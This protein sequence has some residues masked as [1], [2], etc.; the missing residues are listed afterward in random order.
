MDLV[1]LLDS[2]RS[3]GANNFLR[4]K[5]LMIEVV[6]AINIDDGKV[7]VAVVTF[8]T[9]SAVEFFLDDFT[10]KKD[11]QKKIKG[12]VYLEGYTNIASGLSLVKD[13]VFQVNKGDR[14]SVRNVLLLIVDGPSNRNS[15]LTIPTAMLLKESGVHVFVLG[16]QSADVDE[17][18]GI[19]S[20]PTEINCIKGQF[21]DLEHIEEYLFKTMCTGVARAEAMSSAVST[22]APTTPDVPS[23]SWN[24]VTTTTDTTPT[25]TSTTS[26]ETTTTSKIISTTKTAEGTAITGSTASDTTK[27]STTSARATTTEATSVHTTRAGNTTP[28]TSIT[29]T[30]TAGL[31]ATD[32]TPLFTTTEGTGSTTPVT[33]AAKDT[34]PTSF[35]TL[36]TGSTTPSTS[37]NSISTTG[38]T[39][40]TTTDTINPAST[41]ASVPAP[42]LTTDGSTTTGFSTS[43]ACYRR[44]DQAAAYTPEITDDIF[45]DLQLPKRELSKQI[46]K[47]TSTSNLSK[48][49]MVTGMGVSLVLLAPFVCLV[50]WDV[51]D[52]IRYIDRRFR[53]KDRQGFY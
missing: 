13:D 40:T 33:S 46:D 43:N 31:T 51:L 49:E 26:P 29:S 10:S 52:F 5:E 45:K 8:S 1:M 36:P 20:D 23:S 25:G 2:S 32:A 42:G 6:T 34:T 47:R 22:T 53:N 38:A 16:I 7:R 48:S 15:S 14:P 35:Y 44:C 41:T 11:V 3:V 37:M 18:T 17:I 9:S 24:G 19:A 39:T 12:M 28:F 30:T 4:L 21:D 50:G 27:T